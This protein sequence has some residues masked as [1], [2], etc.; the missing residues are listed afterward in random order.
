ML[1]KVEYINKKI[2]DLFVFTKG[3]NEFNRKTINIDK[4]DFPV[5]SGQTENNGIIGYSN[6]FN[7]DGNF[8][9]SLLLVMLETLLLLKENFL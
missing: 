2:S 1:N 6:K 7:H 3:T 4:G 5:Y 9:R 8:I